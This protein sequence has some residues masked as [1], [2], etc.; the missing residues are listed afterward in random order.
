M[1]EYINLSGVE[2]NI[3][4]ALNNMGLPNKTDSEKIINYLIKNK[5]A[6]NADESIE[7]TRIYPNSPPGTMCLMI[8]QTGYYVN[9]KIS[10]IV[11]CALLL[12]INLTK[13]FASTA[14]ALMGV[15]SAAFVKLNEYD[16]QKCI[17]KE[18][19]A[20]KDKIGSEK[21]L[22]KFCGE[23]CNCDLTCKYRHEGHC[24]C[25]S[26]NIVKIYDLLANKNMFKKVN[27]IYKYQW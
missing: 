9:I 7:L 8:A 12:D 14:I 16:G 11:I 27:G 13:G 6:L 22:D 21:I 5:S 4:N 15:P 24:T 1:S 3:Y 23:C 17:V 2:K 10:T 18:T 26:S 20:T 19:L 25:S